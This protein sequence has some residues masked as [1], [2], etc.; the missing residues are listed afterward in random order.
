M[1]V[2]YRLSEQNTAP[3][4][5]PDGGVSI[6]GRHIRHTEPFA[7]MAGMVPDIVKRALVRKRFGGKCRSTGDGPL[8]LVDVAVS[9]FRFRELNGHQ[10]RGSRLPLVTRNGLGDPTR[11]GAPHIAN[12]SFYGLLHSPFCPLST[13]PG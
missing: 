11:T 1:T 9:D 4:K 7:L 13:A 12:I 10:D 2:L 3:L 5:V 6:A 8:H